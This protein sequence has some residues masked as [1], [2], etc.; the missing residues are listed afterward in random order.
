MLNVATMDDESPSG[1]S[2]RWQVS[3]LCV[4]ANPHSYERT[5]MGVK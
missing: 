1:A 2:I 3:R 5:D 4:C